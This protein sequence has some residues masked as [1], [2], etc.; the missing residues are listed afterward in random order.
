[1]RS[2]MLQRLVLSF[3]WCDLELFVEFSSQSDISLSLYVIFYFLCVRMHRQEWCGVW[4]FS[5]ISFVIRK[6]NWVHL[7]ESNAKMKGILRFVP[8][9]THIWNCYCLNVFTA[10]LYNVMH[11]SDWMNPC[12][13]PDNIEVYIGIIKL[14]EKLKISPSAE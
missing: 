9:I 5:L 13:T 3:T 7:Q 11:I 14:W 1:M 4:P 2:L 8:K 10:Y 6:G 12:T